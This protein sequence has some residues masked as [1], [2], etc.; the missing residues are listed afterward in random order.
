V[1]KICYAFVDCETTGLPT[2]RYFSA[3]DVSGWPHLVQLAWA[4]Y[5]SSGEP[6]ENRCHIIRPAG[7]KIPKEATLIHG[8]SQARALRVGEDLGQIL[9]DFLRAIERPGTVL[10]AHNLAF[11]L[12]VIGSEFVRM[13]MP[14]GFLDL[15]G[16][17]TMKAT[18]DLCRL[19]RSWGY[20]FKWPTLE[21]LHA[22]LFGGSYDRPHDAGRDV[23][24]CARCFFEL[25]RIGLVGV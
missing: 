2:S 12:G 25:K 6:V 8:I 15:P 5:E 16:F 1:N 20:G 23:E 11:D 14:A 24:A 7:F 10:V 13:N 17:C 3:L 9:S 4:I 21:E 19:P 22:H 18:T